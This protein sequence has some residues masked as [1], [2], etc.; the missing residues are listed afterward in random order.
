M[1]E[2]QNKKIPLFLVTGLLFLAAISAA[3][4]LGVRPLNNHECFVSVTSREMLQSGDWIMPTFNGQRRLQKTPLSYWLVVLLA[5]S[6]GR[7]DE[8]TSRLPSAVSAVLSVAAILFFVSRVLSFR[9]AMVSAAVWV[10]SLAYIR[11]AHNARP[12]MLMTLFIII[13]FLS[14]YAA[15]VAPTRKEQVVYMLVFWV[16][17]GV[18]NLAKGPAPIPLVLFPLSVYVLVRKQW[19]IIPKLL[20][21][22]GTLIFLAILLPWV[23]A[24]A[25]RVNWDLVL[26]KNEYFDRFFGDY[27][28]GNKA[29]YY[30]LPV[31]FMFVAPYCAFLPIA[32]AAPFY[33]VWENKRPFVQFLWICFIAG[34]A[35]ITI[36]RG[37]RQHYILPYMAVMAILIGILI[38]DMVFVRKAF[39]ARFVKDI[40]RAHVIVAL[41]AAVGL[42][43]YIACAY[44]EL[45]KASV[46]VAV[47]LAAVAVII[48][49]LFA[50]GR[51]IAGCSAAFTGIVVLVA[52]A[53]SVLVNPANYN[54]PSRQFTLAVA[55]MVPPS[56]KLVAFRVASARFVHYSGRI[57]PE[58]Q[59]VGELE[60]LYQQGCWIA[61][62]GKDVNDLAANNRFEVAYS[63][64]KAERF[65]SEDVGASLFHKSSQLQSPQQ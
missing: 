25:Q 39:N 10:T 14:F 15:L 51:T 30:Y 54:E 57:V 20:P 46:S 40:L 36:S 2:I 61:A 1:A 50:K 24:V 13:C 9:T 18:A 8:F 63:Q 34:F 16:S 65:R 48:T 41:I 35:F 31:M 52:L 55:E 23:L 32:L 12:E 49:V 42:P 5:K 7:V 11:Y 38:E 33:K 29:F 56:D 58:I 60:N 64:A 43:F 3:W 53:Y 47:L 28:S 37:K 26:W 45:L 59:D 44:P 6:A 17:F 19:R 21:L 22:A 27:A 62:F 4:T